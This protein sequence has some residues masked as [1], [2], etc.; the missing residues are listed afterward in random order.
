MV[1]WLISEVSTRLFKIFPSRGFLMVI[2]TPESITWIMFS[3]PRKGFKHFPCSISFDYNLRSLNRISFWDVH[4]E[5]NMVQ[6][7]AKVAELES[8]TFQLAKS[9]DAGVN[10]DLLSKTI[11]SVVGDKHHGHPVISGVTRNLFRAIAI[12]IYQNFHYPVA[13]L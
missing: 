5:V 9:L 2:S 7:E 3:K 10:V 8:K 6:G 4:Q 11:I 1:I 12:F 13:L